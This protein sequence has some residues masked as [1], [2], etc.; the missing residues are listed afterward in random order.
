MLHPT[1]QGSGVPQSPASVPAQGAPRLLLAAKRHLIT[2][3]TRVP[4]HANC[5]LLS[6]KTGQGQVRARRCFQTQ[7][8]DPKGRTE[9][10]GA[11]RDRPR[12]CSVACF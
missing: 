7:S 12:Q 5:S 1:P 9:I 10:L 6:P 11:R 4:Q 3:S 2:V 8:C